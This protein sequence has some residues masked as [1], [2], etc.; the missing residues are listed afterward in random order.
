MR[1]GPRRLVGPWRA[2]GH[3]PGLGPDEAVLALDLGAS[4]I[5][6]AVVTGNGRIL[7]RSEGLTPGAEGPDAVVRACIQHL[8]IARD[9][10]DAGSPRIVGAGLCAPG[11]LDPRTGIL[12]EPPNFGQGF[13]DV[14]LAGP[15]GQA[16]GIPTFLER[17]TNVAALGELTFG[18]AQGVQDFLYVTVSTGLGGSIVIG[19]RLYGGPDGVAGELG[20]QVID[21]DGPLCNCGG[22]GHLE[23]LCSGT[24]LAKLGTQAARNG[25]SA[26]L[27]AAV[28]ARGE[29]GLEGRDVAD[30]AVAGDPASE[31]IIE[32]AVRAFAAACVSYANVFSPELIVVG[33]SMAMGMGDRLLGPARLAVAT[34]AFRIPRA[35]LR[36][37]PAALG[38]DVGLLGAVPLLAHRR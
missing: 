16:L 32:R 9:E 20:H 19:G 15:I 1:P 18:S 8:L 28:V 24:A 7:T 13:V 3:A 23:A 35:R 36:I 11:P 10:L 17:D 2:Q 29:A 22:R 21:L 38:D 4:R 37:V 33:G 27:S 12:V 30:A 34:A 25:K 6:A 26:V 5:R 14:P 31:A